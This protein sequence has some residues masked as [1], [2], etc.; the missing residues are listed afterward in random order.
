MYGISRSATAWPSILQQ[1][2]ALSSLPTLVIA[3]L[4]CKL[5]GNYSE[6]FRVSKWLSIIG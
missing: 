2:G 3:V 1:A 5:P 6:M 4:I